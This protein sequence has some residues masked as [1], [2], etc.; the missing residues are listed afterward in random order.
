MKIE[1]AP[2]VGV[3]SQDVQEM[4]REEREHRLWLRGYPRVPGPRTRIWTRSEA[5]DLLRGIDE[6]SKIGTREKLLT[7]SINHIEA[8]MRGHLGFRQFHL[9]DDPEPGDF[10]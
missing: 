8:Q 2:L 6:I 3:A 7:L 4:S 5:I 10:L 9:I 1:T